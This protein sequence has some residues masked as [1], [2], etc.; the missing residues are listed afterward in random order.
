MRV[1]RRMLWNGAVTVSVVLSH[2]GKLSAVPSIAQSGLADGEI[3]S[4]F[5]AAASIAVEDAIDALG[6]AARRNDTSVEEVVSQTVRRVARSMFGSRP[7]A[8]VHI[9]RV[10]AEDF[11]A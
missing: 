7:I 5:I 2:L 1:R 10:G 11:R 3:A 4:D 9:V 6:N 8:H